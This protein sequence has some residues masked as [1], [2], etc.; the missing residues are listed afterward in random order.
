MSKKKKKHLL[1]YRFYRVYFTVLGAALV[2]ILGFTVWLMGYLREVESAQPGYVAQDVAR[3]F[4]EKDFDSLYDLDSAARSISDGDRDFY[5]ENL[6]EIAQG[7]T[8][9]WSEGFSEVEDQ[10][11]YN[12]TLDG[13]RFASFVLVPSGQTTRRGQRL[14]TLGYV[15][16]NVA[17][18]EAA[19]TPTVPV[20]TP[21]PAPVS[22][23]RVT[24]PQGYIV[25]VDGEELTAENAAR[26][27]SP[28][29]EEGFLP[30][31]VA[32][33]VMVTYD[34][35]SM[36]ENPQVAVTDLFGSPVQVTMTADNVYSC[37]L[38]QSAALQQSYGEAVMSLAKKIAKYTSKDGSKNAILSYCAKDSP[39]RT[40][41]NNLSNQYATP[42]SEVA[43]QN[44]AVG[45]FYE[46]SAD[47]FTCR[48]T[49]D[50]LMKT[51]DGVKTDPTAYTFCITGT[52]SDIKLYNL[53]MS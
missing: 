40:V 3:L 43:F 16:T 25:S 35:G 31:S 24:A 15:T 50:Y 46:M 1:D 39:A 9:Q 51:R 22:R 8:V 19:P 13:E 38:P 47:C 18:Q 14:W 41:F 29:F 27:E 11:K 4:V 37:T 2:L 32:M 10:R 49:F 34:Y 53:L 52:G 7:K 5:V 26:S 6:S 30:A 44:E 36:S 17:V 23:L 48:V 12:V 42:H 28:L 33:P 21:T 45:E 20:V